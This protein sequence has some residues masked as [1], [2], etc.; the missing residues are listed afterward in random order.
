MTIQNI[1][2]YIGFFKEREVSF[3]EFIE[4][5][6]TAKREKN[7]LILITI[8]VFFLNITRIN[9]MKMLY[10]ATD[11]MGYVGIATHFAGLDWTGVMKF[12]PFYSYGY[13]II[14]YPLAKIFKQPESLYSSIIVVN[15]IFI[16]L[17]VP[18]SYYFMKK[19][20]KNINKYVLMAASFAVALYSSNV[21][22]AHSAMT[23]ALLI[24][25][26]WCLIYIFQN[27]NKSESIKHILCFSVLL[28]YIYMV[29]Q[30]TIAIIIAAFIVITVMFCRK[31]INRKKYVLFIGTL[32]IMFLIHRFIKD[33]IKESVFSNGTLL[34][35]NDFSGQTGKILELFTLSGLGSFLRNIVG[36]LLYF[37]TSTYFIG[38]VALIYL[39]KKNYKYIKEIFAKNLNKE[40]NIEK[41]NYM[42]LEMYILLLFLG[43]FFIS[44]IF[45][46]NPVRLD[47]VFYG[48][49]LEIVVM[50]ILCIGFVKMLENDFYSK[51]MFLSMSVFFISITIISHFAIMNMP[52]L[53]FGRVNVVAIAPFHY[54]EKLHLF[55]NFLFTIVLSFI[56]FLI[57]KKANNFKN[58]ILIICLAFV[59]LA[60][61][62]AN[63]NATLKYI[64]KVYGYKKPLQIVKNDENIE[65]I[66]YYGYKLTID[67]S[68]IQYL[69]YDRPLIAL[70]SQEKGMYQKTFLEDKTNPILKGNYYLVS[71]FLSEEIL[72]NY[73]MDDFI[74]GLFFLSK[75]SESEVKLNE[76]I[77]TIPSYKFAKSTGKIEDGDTVSDGK[78]GFLFG[79]SSFS[80]E[81]GKYNFNIEIE[82]ISTTTPNIG[83]V[84][85]KNLDPNIKILNME[86]KEENFVDNKII[87]NIKREFGSSFY[88]VQPNIYTNEGVILKVKS[89]SITT[90]T[91]DAVQEE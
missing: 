26:V 61:G 84:I 53:A 78:K 68:Y 54:Y 58:I 62:I 39:I 71:E 27:I 6:I 2:L 81:P 23:E 67:S 89:F 57:A 41:N 18:L 9:E 25:C 38:Y 37:G 16:S 60:T 12:L 21:V 83:N 86:L 82:L 17:I 29:H 14:I 49:Y 63:I 33:Y 31:N 36:H 56:I 22:R 3:L 24:L 80:L 51:K 4:K 7:L 64:N 19:I 91:D 13:S 11:E 87:L 1:S 46:V 52:A 88:E 79:N 90:Y 72:N 42:Y 30:R 47:V 48:R 75:K 43:M 20:S 35:L 15:A 66:Y 55:Y 85:I 73:K 77:F 28:G 69:L 32:V 44:C 34:E 5:E 8:F 65:N 70:N 76:K 45:M 50:P 40:E 10:L 74:N 59:S